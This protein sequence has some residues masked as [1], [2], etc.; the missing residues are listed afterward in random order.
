MK[1]KN[2]N[3]NIFVFLIS[4]S[5][6]LN[7]MYSQPPA[8]DNFTFHFENNFEDDP[9]GRYSDADYRSDW[10]MSSGGT[11][12]EIEV[13]DIISEN[14]SYFKKFWRGYLEQGKYQPANQGW[15]WNSP[16]SKTHK[17][18]YFSYDIRFKPGFEWVLGGKIPGIGGGKLVSGV[19]PSITDGFSVRLM[20]KD[21]G[22]LVFY[23]YHQ[24]QQIIFG[25]S[26]YWKDFSFISG[27]WY[28]ITFRVV[29]N[30]VNND[31]GL[32]DGIIE[33]FI[34]GK[35]MYQK[36]D[37]RFRNLASIE[38]DKMI[39]SAFFGGND[40][41]W[42]STRDEWIDTDNYVAY[43]YS[44]KP[45]NVPRGK[46]LSSWTRMLLHPYRVF[47]SITES[48]APVAPV[49]LSATAISKASI[50]LKWT[51][52][53][54]NEQGFNLYRSLS[55]SDGFIEIA[56]LPANM[57]TYKNDSLL[58]G[59][60]YYYKLRAY[61]QD[62]YS[63]YTPVLQV[64]TSLLD[65]PAPPTLFISTGQ[66][67]SSISLSWKDNSSR[68]QGFTLFRSISASDGFAEAAS[69]PSNATAYT[70]TSLQP[71]TIYYYKLRAY[72]QDGSSEYAPLLQVETTPAQATTIF[73][74]PPVIKDQEFIVNESNFSGNIIGRISS[75]DPD[76]G[77]KLSYS[78][79]SGNASGLFRINSQTG[80]LK[81]T[82]D[83]IFGAGTLK[84]DLVVSVIDDAIEP[85]S[86]TASIIIKLVGN[87]N[88][89]YINPEN[90]NDA[91]ANGS[92]YHPYP[93]WDDVTWKEGFNYLQKRGTSVQVEKVIIGAS[94]VTLGDYGEGELPVI[95]SNT[96]TYLIVGFDKSN[97]KVQNLRL[98][99]SKAVSCIYFLGNMCDSI[100]IDHCI[101]T[102]SDNAIKM[103]GGK[104]LISK[105]N[106]ITSEHEG[107]NS[108]ATDNNIYYNIFK[109]C[110][111]AVNVMSNQSKAN[112]FNNIFIDN[113]Q[114]ISVSYAE[115]TLY[116]N[117]FYMTAPGQKALTHGKDKIVSDNN[118][119]YP[120]QDG[121]I[122]VANKSFN[123]LTQ[124]QLDLKTDISS[125]SSDPQFVDLYNNN[126]N[127]EETSPAINAGKDLN[128]IKD[129]NG[130]VVPFAGVTDIGILEFTGTLLNKN[131]DSGK[132][133]VMSLYPN[134]STGK[135]N[136]QAEI[137]QER[138]EDEYT[139]D[140][141]E[142]KVIDIS[143]NTVFM[144][145]IVR[146]GSI[147]QEN[148]DLS[149]ISNG[150][151]F[152]ILQ[153]ADKVIKEKLLI[154]K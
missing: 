42:A 17:E 105:Y 119:F 87:S 118:I 116:N 69:I 140:H 121:F 56:S 3:L 135:V 68:E 28:N 108:S 127:L 130:V 142:L 126:F 23:V 25:D 125:F 4:A 62:G 2:V 67:Q 112:I 85:K 90:T 54:T 41:A 110:I 75:T 5:F 48:S 64:T 8:R 102:A 147:I 152:I 95:T 76:A 79:K 70:D 65:L 30:T 45:T 128:L 99:S 115:L 153:M 92:I 1:S 59:T 94:H 61:N 89:V 16:F 100:I 40:E 11:L 83:K 13:F 20:W 101:L 74:N 149:R 57:N 52:N 46:E 39:I 27:K 15:Y 93:S 107:V 51:D 141:T 6:G 26:Y 123:K 55:P 133:S 34:D 114:S 124:L 138:P 63:A 98:Q 131:E 14:D 53:S 104:T 103:A 137:V 148:I 32:K 120:E 88:T 145:Q 91:I 24:D 31:V 106:T 150:L 154:N 117:I 36:S 86:A 82:T 144:K 134:P 73:N 22:K 111:T 136:I 9:L 81:A 143:G 21:N 151:Y 58:K 109:K 43:T 84:H 96:N 19:K 50:S 60:N 7:V 71:V 12:S 139:Y 33:G 129:F 113:E 132:T 122:E 80:E 78:I 66:T 97:I 47:S 38:L 49:S 10:N 37:L 77:Q 18:L 146:K 29:L 44:D 72:N 35:L